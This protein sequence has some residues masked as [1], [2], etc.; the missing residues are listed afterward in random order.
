MPQPCNSSGGSGTLTRDKR[1]STI[2]TAK[3]QGEEGLYRVSWSLRSEANADERSIP[4]V[5]VSWTPGL[6]ENGTPW[7]LV[8]DAS[9][10]VA[11][12]A[13]GGVSIAAGFDE[14]ITPP[15]GYTCTIDGG[16][17]QVEAEGTTSAT[18]TRYVQS[19]ATGAT[20]TTPAPRFA[21]GVQ[22]KATTPSPDFLFQSTTR[23]GA[24]AG[25]S[26]MG[27]EA[28]RIAGTVLAD[29]PVFRLLPGAVSATLTNTRGTDINGGWVVF[30][31]GFGPN[32]I[33]SLATG[34]T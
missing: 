26:R 21:Q 5:L 25:Y 31:L 7:V 20:L 24:L 10:G 23:G 11:Y 4:R 30:Y 15:V 22:L 32:S 9:S 17:L 19:I 28:S 14:S 2:A 16:I 13:G 3:R 27:G 8:A 6:A 29:D 18:L 33:P 1:Q 34:P 12:V